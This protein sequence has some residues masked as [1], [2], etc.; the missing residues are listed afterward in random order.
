MIDH[1]PRELSRVH[2]PTFVAL[3]LIPK[4]DRIQKNRALLYGV[5]KAIFIIKFMLH[6]RVSGL[7]FASPE[8]YL[9]KPIPNPPTALT[10]QNDQHIFVVVY[11]CNTDI[12][13]PQTKSLLLGIRGATSRAHILSK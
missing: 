1:E 9:Y 10:Q 7:R 8:S 11:V 5:T 12:Q 13:I 2:A 4:F 3:L 6:T